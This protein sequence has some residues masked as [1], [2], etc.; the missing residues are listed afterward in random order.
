MI[1]IREKALLSLR[2]N[3]SWIRIFA[4]VYHKHDD[5]HYNKLP[6][7]NIRNRHIIGSEVQEFI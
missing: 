6:K 2:E 1:K 3:M 7:I 5:E 4:T